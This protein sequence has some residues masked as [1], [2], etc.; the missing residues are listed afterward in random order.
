MTLRDLGD[1]AVDLYKIT[2]A[3][4]SPPIYSSITYSTWNIKHVQ[5]KPNAS[6]AER[7]NEQCKAGKQVRHASRPNTAEMPYPQSRSSGSNQH[8]KYVKRYQE[9]R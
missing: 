9:S 2:R 1:S 5:E 4:Y 3:Y 6:N 8:G 7:R